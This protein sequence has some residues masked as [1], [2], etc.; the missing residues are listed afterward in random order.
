MMLVY[1]CMKNGAFLGGKRCFL[2]GK[3]LFSFGEEGG[4]QKKKRT[5]VAFSSFLLSFCPYLGFR[6]AGRRSSRR[7]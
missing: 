7:P 3:A 5:S 4:A 1:A 2:D 6:T